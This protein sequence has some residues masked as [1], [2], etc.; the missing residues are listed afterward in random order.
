MVKVMTLFG[1]FLKASEQE[2]ALDVARTFMILDG[3]MKLLSCAQDFAEKAGCHKLADKIA[4]LSRSGSRASSAPT[5]QKVSPMQMALPK[6]VQKVAQPLFEEGEFERRAENAV[7]DTDNA[8]AAPPSEARNV[9][10]PIR[11][12]SSSTVVSPTPVSMPSASPPSETGSV[13]LVQPSRSVSDLGDR[14]SVDSPAGAAAG[15]A[16]AAA[17]SANPFARKRKP[18][19]ASARAPHLLRDALGSGVRRPAATPMNS[20]VAGSVPEAPSKVARTS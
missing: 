3:S 10:S 20:T 18:A 8:T 1:S 12:T 7:R 15:K 19:E 2:R 5:S 13:P 4:E 11:K 16:G 6:V 14:A 9:A 17:V